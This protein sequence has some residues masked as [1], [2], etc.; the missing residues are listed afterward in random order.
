MTV[1]WAAGPDH[2]GTLDLPPDELRRISAWMASH[3]LDPQ[4]VRNVTV[5]Q[6]GRAAW[7]EAEVLVPLPTGIYGRQ[8]RRRD[9]FTPPPV[10][11]TA[12][13]PEVLRRAG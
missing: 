2:P 12:P 3:D 13:E 7:I 5:V 9:L 1:V 4:A 8:V 11:W 10:P 6:G